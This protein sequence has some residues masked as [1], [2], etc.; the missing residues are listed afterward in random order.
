MNPLFSLRALAAPASPAAPRVPPAFGA[1]A[2][3]P[4]A[5]ATLAALG[6]FGVAAAL[7][8]AFPSSAAAEDWPDNPENAAAEFGRPED[9]YFGRGVDFTAEGQRVTSLSRG[10]LIWSGTAPSAA[11]EPLI[12]LEHEGGFRSAYR[13]VNPRPD[14]HGTVLNGDWLGYADSD[15]W[16]FEIYDSMQSRIVDPETLLPARPK[17]RASTSLRVTLIRDNREIPLRD[18]MTAA[19]GLWTVAVEGTVPREIDLYR[20]GESIAALRFDSLAE[21][22]GRVVMETPDP[23]VFEDIYDEA[24]RVLFRGILLNAGRTSLQLRVRGKDGETF[25]RTW[26]LNIRG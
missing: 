12:V 13:R 15:T 4:S 22:E 10:E 16:A 21:V 6:V 5:P 1:P 20:L 8:T 24:G 11:G 9:G 26:N 23:A 7:L 17:P 25:S 19:P 2:A 3:A 18:G 14:L